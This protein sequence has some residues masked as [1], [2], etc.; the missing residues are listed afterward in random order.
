MVDLESA[1]AAN[2]AAVNEMLSAADACA[3]DWRK[4]RAP[5]KWSGSQVVEHVARSY[6]ES[7][8]SMLGQPSKLPNVPALLR[9]LLRLLFFQPSLRKGGFGK[10]RTNKA[11][12]PAG[13]PDSPAAGRTRLEGALGKFEEACRLSA[14]RGPHFSSSIFGKTGIADYVRFQELHTRHHTRQIPV[15]GRVTA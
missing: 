10:A 8:A 15:D 13:G 1:L 9:P 6:E 2:R 4:P 12:D 3:N 5:G 7:A 11:M 14:L